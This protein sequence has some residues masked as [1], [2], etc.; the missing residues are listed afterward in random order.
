MLFDYLDIL[1]F[2]YAKSL[3]YIS[4]IIKD[5]NFLLPLHDTQIQPYDIK[6][7]EQC[8]NDNLNVLANT[9]EYLKEYSWDK[10]NTGSWR[11]VDEC[12]RLMYAI[13]SLL[14]IYSDL[15]KLDDLQ[16]KNPQAVM[17]LI[18]ECD[19][20]ILLGGPQME[21]VFNQL[22]SII[23][24]ECKEC[25]N[26]QLCFDDYPDMYTTISSEDIVKYPL[27]IESRPS[28][29][30]F[31]REFVL[32]KTPVLLKDC[33][34]EWPAIHKWSINYLCQNIG[35]RTVP[36]EIGSK[37]TEN[38]W[39]QKLMLFKNFVRDYIQQKRPIIRVIKAAN[40]GCLSFSSNPLADPLLFGSED[41]TL[42]I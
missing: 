36:I 42:A 41:D 3:S 19:R 8:L 13:C 34:S 5:D 25:N 40:C 4:S 15:K 22:L 31:Y 23:D 11:Q 6:C 7:I 9:V 30:T 28:L 18:K 1:A 38:S 33:I 37:Y 21:P 39:T 32:N 16:I 2:M 10:L 20:G 26:D 27:R 12:W 29:E 17:D 35:N 14:A 24:I